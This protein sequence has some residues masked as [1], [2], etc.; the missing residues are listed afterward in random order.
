M[1][2]QNLNIEKIINDPT[3]SKSIYLIAG[4][5]I[6][7]IVVRFLQQ[8]IFSKINDNQ[9]AYRAKKI[10]GFI[11]YILLFFLILTTFNDKLPNL[12]VAFG[13]AGAGIAFALQEVITSF[14]GWLTIVIGKAFKTGD[15]IQLGGI[16]GDVI[17]IGM[18]RTTLMET[19]QWVDGDLYNGRIVLVANSFVF[20]EPV[21]NYSGDFPFLWDEL[22]VPIKITS[23]FD[24]A[25]ESFTKILNDVQGIYA[26]KAILHWKKI[27]EKMM[28][29]N[30]QVAPM[31]KMTFDEN[32]ITFTLRYVVDFKKRRGTKDIL[33]RKVLEA[34]KSS[35][36]KIEVASSA[37]EVT[38]LPK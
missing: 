4:F 16:K 37:M 32:W 26:E 33:S 17:D 12:S 29:E 13:V 20:K 14:A 1:Q 21:Y 36:G 5:I 8:R 23:D 24:F 6:I 22:K 10:T 2:P 31:V 30:A 34:I 27:T 9:S 3:F 19:G 35:D 18:L 28:V 7:W 25:T 11:G 38:L 15:R